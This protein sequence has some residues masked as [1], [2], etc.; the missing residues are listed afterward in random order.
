MERT[1]YGVKFFHSHPHYY[2]IN[3]GV[4]W[5]SSRINNLVIEM[6]QTRKQKRLAKQILDNLEPKIVPKGT[7]G[8]LIREFTRIHS[9]K[10]RKRK[11][12]VTPRI[13]GPQMKWNEIKQDALLP[14][15]EWDDWCDHRDGFRDTIRLPKEEVKKIYERIKIKAKIR[16][17][18]HDKNK[19]LLDSDLD[20][21]T[22]PDPI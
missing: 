15:E 9:K 20:S 16:K 8:M 11:G 7:P 2:A 17:A 4:P 19:H 13:T 22:S 18:R 1:A 6:K 12:H 21:K 5:K 14:P 3:F 10:D